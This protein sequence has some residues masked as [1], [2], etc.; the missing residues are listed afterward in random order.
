[1][2]RF[3]KMKGVVFM[4]KIIENVRGMLIDEAKRQISENGYES[5]TIRGIAKGCSLG[6]GTFYNYFKSK[7]LLIAS[8]LLEDWQERMQRV[9][10]MTESIQ[11]P[12]EI[13]RALHEEISAFI[14][15]NINI[16]NSPNAKKAFETTVGTYHRLLRAQISAPILTVCKAAGYENAE[17]L[18][19]FVAESTLTW[20]VARKSFDEISSLVS[21]LFVK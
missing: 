12:M 7:D 19:D 14:D 13:V 1:M 21:K 6:L 4:P 3:I 10:Q 17:F 16:F 9:T 5:V 15:A 20:T 2:N 18:A 11:D 8:F